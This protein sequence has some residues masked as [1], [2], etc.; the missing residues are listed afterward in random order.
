M[1]SN[2]SVPGIHGH[3]ENALIKSFK[4]SSHLISLHAIIKIPFGPASGSGLDLGPK[5]MLLVLANRHIKWGAYFKALKEGVLLAPMDSRYTQVG[6][7][8]IS[9]VN[10]GRQI[11]M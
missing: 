8:S 5:G 11:Q 3:Q 2:L 1:E 7:N 6:F 10:S 9:V 4:M